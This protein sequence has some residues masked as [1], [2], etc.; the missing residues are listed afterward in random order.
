[1]QQNTNGLVV[2]VMRNPG[3]FGCFAEDLVSRLV[4]QPFHDV[5]AQLRP[6]LSEVQAYKQ[7]VQDATSFGSPNWVVAVLQQQP[8]A[9][10]FLLTVDTQQRTVVVR[11]V[12][13]AQESGRSYELWLVSSKYPKH[14]P[15]TGHKSYS[16]NSTQ[17]KE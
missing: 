17:L 12:S 5:T 1:M 16:Y 4:L 9:P 8:I 2:D 7:A 13:A 15:L 14:T 10:A 6:T 3:G 11:R